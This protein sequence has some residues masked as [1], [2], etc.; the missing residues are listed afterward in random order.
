VARANFAAALSEG[1]LNADATPPAFA[2]LVARNAQAGEPVEAVGFFGELLMGRRPDAA[3]AGAIWQAAA[4]AGPGPDRL[5]RSVALLL[6]R[7]EAQL[8]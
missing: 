7:P 8:V 3:A 5:G 6:A 2:E 1:R 4:D